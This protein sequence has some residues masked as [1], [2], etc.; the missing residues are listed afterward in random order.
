MK[1][2]KSAQFSV[3]KLYTKWS[4][5]SFW[6]SSILSHSTPLH[7]TLYC[8]SFLTSP[9]IHSIP[10]CYN[11]NN[12]FTVNQPVALLVDPPACQQASPHPSHQPT[13]PLHLLVIVSSSNYST[14][15]IMLY[16]ILLQYSIKSCSNFVVY[17]HILPWISWFLIFFHTFLHSS[18][19]YNYFYRTC[20]LTNLSAF[21]LSYDIIQRDIT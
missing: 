7:P 8:S 4:I 13:L 3:T 9:L 12:H 6:L 21:S 16:Y 2:T 18:C 5:L 17:L 20:I 14:R 1:K 11:F 10:F 19:A 15:I